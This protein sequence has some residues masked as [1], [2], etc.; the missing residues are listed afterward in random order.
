M[1]CLLLRLQ[2]CRSHQMTRS[3][4]NRHSQK[5][6]ILSGL[7]AVITGALLIML[8]A[9]DSS[10][11]SPK[12]SGSSSPASASTLTPSPPMKISAGPPSMDHVL[13]NGMAYI[14]ARKAM[15]GHGWEPTKNAQCRS[16]VVGDD[17]RD[18]C[19]RD[20]DL[21]RPCDELPELDACSAD[22]Y[23]LMKFHQSSHNLNVTTYGDITAWSKHEPQSELSVQNWEVQ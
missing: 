13:S 14:D 4:L 6:P 3:M 10:S 2:P 22:G 7:K 1:P 18:Q 12:S 5:T 19:S 15:L 16:D 23:C 11:S 20:K 21:C 17:Y 9:C 8:C